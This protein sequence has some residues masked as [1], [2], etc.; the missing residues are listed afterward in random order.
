MPN[1]QATL[2]DSSTNT[3]DVSIDTDCSILT[4]EDNSNYTT[5]DEDGHENADFADYRQLEISSPDG[6]TYDYDAQGNLDAAWDQGTSRNNTL[7][8]TLASSDLDGVYVLTLFS[9]PTYKSSVSYTHTT[10]SPKSVYY[11]NKIWQTIQTTPSSNT[12]E[13]GSEYWKEI[14]R[15]DLSSK[16]KATATFSLTCR[17]LNQC[18]E[19]LTLEAGCTVSGDSCDDDLLCGNTSFLNQVKLKT[20]I[21]G[22]GYASD[23]GDFTEATNLVNAAKSICNC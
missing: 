13:S 6:S 10:A 2:I 23:A 18:L 22:I 17:E 19:R 9:V 8:R 21:D 20:L 4:F 12:P 3:I 1:F 11:N 7:N 5:S 14:T 16:Y 15:K